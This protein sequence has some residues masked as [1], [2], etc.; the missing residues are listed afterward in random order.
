[1]GQSQRDHNYCIKWPS[2]YVYKMDMKYTW[3]LSLDLGPPNISLCIC[4]YSKI[5]KQNKTVAQNTSGLKH[6][7]W[8]I[9]RSNRNTGGGGMV[10]MIVKIT[11]DSLLDPDLCSARPLMI[12]FPFQNP[13]TNMWLFS[14]GLQMRTPQVLEVM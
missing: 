4:K 13:R 12:L 11:F 5:C 7:G 9:L 6:F 14:P 10:E 8:G 1:M 3:L 2:G